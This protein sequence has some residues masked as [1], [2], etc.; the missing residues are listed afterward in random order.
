MN[1]VFAVQDKVTQNIVAALKVH[2]TDKE[3]AARTQQET[4][5]P[6]AYDAFLRG[7]THYD[8]Y[9]QD[10]FAT[11]IP[12]LEKAIQLD[13]NYA[14][15]HGVLAAVYWAI[16][17]NQ[18]APSMGMDYDDTLTKMEHHL[19]EALKN[20]TPLAHHIASRLLTSQGQSDEAIAESKRAIALDPNDANGY[21]ALARI[22]IKVGRPAEALEAMKKAMRLDPQGDVRGTFSYRLGE[23]YFH[24]DRFEESA[25]AFKKYTELRPGDEWGF[26]L[27]AAASGHLERKQDAQS[28]LEKFNHAWA[29][30]GRRHYALADVDGWAFPDETIRERLR[31][32]LRKAGVPPGSSRPPLT[33]RGLQKAP[34]EVEGATTID[35]TEAKALFDRGV[36]FVDLRSDPNWPRGHIP[37]A[38]HLHRAHD[39]TEAKLS[40][41]VAKD[42]EVVLYAC[43]VGCGVTAMAVA[44]A[45]SM[46]FNKV[47]FFRKGW[48]G[49]KAAGY[50]VEVPSG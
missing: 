17:S 9:S 39:V 6:A 31:E 41:V 20:P 27:L 40:K 30:K 46:G 22:Y 3:Q 12:Y 23:S 2:L 5:S 21:T 37:G 14:R 42:G 34:L 8:I 29:K 49:W 10:D 38:V 44:T 15:A 48:P 16:G 43:G 1:D 45:V 7:R 28:A 35:A 36:P 13:P 32:G 11:A 25:A 33:F 24:L 50:P 26:L 4:D 18:W 19:K 47:Y